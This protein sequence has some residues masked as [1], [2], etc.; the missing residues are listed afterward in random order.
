MARSKE[1]EDERSIRE[2]FKRWFAAMEAADIDELLELVTDHVIFKSPGTPAAV[3]RNALE[4]RLDNFHSRFR[5]EVEHDVVEIA[6]IADD[7]AYARVLER[8]HVSARDGDAEADMRGM[9]LTVLRRTED[10]WRIHRDVASLDH[11]MS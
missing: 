11:P 1:Q 9:H 7:W 2:I 5:E 10:G 4:D 6:L 8:S 3:G